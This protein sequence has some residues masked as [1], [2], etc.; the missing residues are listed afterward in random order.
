MKRIMFVCH[1]NICRSPMAEFVFKKI[2]SDHGND[3]DFLI[4]SCAVST[5][6]IGNAVYPP[7]AAELK[8]HGIS[9]EGKHAVQL[10]K[11]DYED[12]DLFLAA[13]ESNIR[14]IMRVFGSDP[15]NKGHLLMEYTGVGHEISDPWYTR[16]FD[17]AYSDIEK[18][19]NAL[20]DMLSD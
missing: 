17:V 10:K 15:E 4:R 2:V 9:C 5:E 19:C 16:R 20:F 8:K 1:G 6:E 12:F 13:D 7:A 14:W 3:E 18:S 11:N